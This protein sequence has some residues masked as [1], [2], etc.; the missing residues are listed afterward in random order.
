LG[1]VTG[2]AAASAGG[3][4]DGRGAPLSFKDG[5]RARPRPAAD[6]RAGLRVVPAA[7]AAPRRGGRQRCSDADEMALSDPS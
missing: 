5:R 3:T 4:E 1:G 7:G 6:A 2:R